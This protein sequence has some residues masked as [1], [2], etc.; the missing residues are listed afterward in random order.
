MSVKG[1]QTKQLIE[2]DEKE[3]E[4]EIELEYNGEIIISADQ[5]IRIN[6]KASGQFNLLKSE[7]DHLITSTLHTALKRNTRKSR[8]VKNTYRLQHESN[9][10]K[11]VASKKYE[12]NPIYAKYEISIRKHCTIC[13]SDQYI[14]LIAYKQLPKFKNRITVYYTDNTCDEIDTGITTL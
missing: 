9:T 5:E 4:E 10:T 11:T 12:V 8:K 1:W 7:I 2:S 14:T 3:E 6:S 13:G